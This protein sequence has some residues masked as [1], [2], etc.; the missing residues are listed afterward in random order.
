[1]TAGIINIIFNNTYSKLY[2]IY[3]ITLHL[4]KEIKELNKEKIK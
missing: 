3:E 2:N 1:M 4:N